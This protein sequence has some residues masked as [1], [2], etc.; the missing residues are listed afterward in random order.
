[1]LLAIT[2]TGKV[3]LLL[4]AATFIG[5][6]L[7]SAIVVPRWRPGFPGDK[8]P[9]FVMACAL[10]F[11][12]QIAAVAWVTGTQEV[13]E[14][15]AAATEVQTAGGG[16]QVAYAQVQ[17]L[18]SK[19][20]CTS[21]HPF[22]NPSLNLQPG[23]SYASLV[24]IQALEDPRLY[25]V[26][27]GDPGRSFLFL[28][29]GGDPPLADIP[30]IGGRMPPAAPPIASSDLALIRTWIEQGAKGPDGKTGGPRVTTPGSPPTG[31][32]AAKKAVSPRGTGTITGTVVDQERRP[33]VGALVTILLK[34]PT[35]QGGEEHYRVAQTDRSGRFTLDHSPAGR[36][37]LKA[38]AP[39]SIYVSRIVALSAG[40][41]QTIDFGIPH[42]V[43]N[44]PNISAARVDG[45]RLSMTV[46]GSSLDGNYTLAANP[47]SGL[48]FELRNPIGG[49]GHWAR[50][51]PRRLAGP[52][53]FLAVDH[54]CNTSAFLT[55]AS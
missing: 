47:S 20:G 36:F 30:A 39:N 26:V 5:F 52:W 55:V 12:A 16:K 27:A 22:V 28:K 32:G 14:K 17:S 3:V 49:P 21:C 24:G 11:G 38:Y 29:V 25:R 10:L 19:Y 13:K 46:R 18:F 8:L 53:V 43:I 41:T 34:G 48:V 37:L 51:V 4:T 23:K 15:A 33:I 50:T 6:A 31:L 35:Q 54:Q 44:N 40:A 1:M 9:L 7:V 45:T 42:R 2:A